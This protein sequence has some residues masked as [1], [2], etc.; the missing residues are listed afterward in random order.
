[1]RLQILP[2]SQQT[3]CIVA[4]RLCTP[5]HTG[6]RDWFGCPGVTDATAILSLCR[7]PAAVYYVLS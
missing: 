6:H 4:S 3:V 1:M 5:T 7:T 2:L